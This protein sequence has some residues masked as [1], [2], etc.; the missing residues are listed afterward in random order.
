MDLLKNLFGPKIPA[1]P[2]ERKPAAAAS[3][4]RPYRRVITLV[5]DDPPDHALPPS[6]PI[7]APSPLKENAEE[8][9]KKMRVRSERSKEL[10]ELAALEPVLAPGKR[11]PKMAALK[12]VVVDAIDSDADQR[13]YRVAFY[14]YQSAVHA[15]R[16]SC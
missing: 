12:Q 5:P 1:Q 2:P 6:K 15:A 8:L 10:A 9:A 14:L 7:P 4:P 11:V 3:L 13:R 16:R